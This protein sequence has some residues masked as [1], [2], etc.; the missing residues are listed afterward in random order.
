MWFVRIAAQETQIQEALQNS[1][2]YKMR[3][4]YK[5]KSCKVTVSYMNCLSRTVIEAAKKYVCLSSQDWLGFEMAQL[6][7]GNNLKTQGCS[8]QM[9][10]LKRLV[11]LSHA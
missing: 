4:A 5:G 2:D 1:T 7:E 6:Q 11:S 10:V 9:L 8:L 3:G